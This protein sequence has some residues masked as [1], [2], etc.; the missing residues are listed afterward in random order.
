[1]IFRIILNW[2]FILPSAP[3]DQRTRRGLVVHP[4]LPCGSSLTYREMPEARCGR[5]LYTYWYYY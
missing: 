4:L 3:L 1:M 2:Q 5:W